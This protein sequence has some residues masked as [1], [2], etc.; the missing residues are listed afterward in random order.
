M[1]EAQAPERQ[2]KR[3][4]TALDLTALGQNLTV[5]QWYDALH[6]WRAATLAEADAAP[7]GGVR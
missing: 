5:E 7:Q 1:R 2:L 4:L 6:V 3:S